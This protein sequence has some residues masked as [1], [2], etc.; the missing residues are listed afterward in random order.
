VTAKAGDT[1]VSDSDVAQYTGEKADEPC[2][3]DGDHH[4][5]G[6]HDRHHKKARHHHHDDGSHEDDSHDGDWQG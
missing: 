5:D 6:D 4:D 3:D 1:D 2:P